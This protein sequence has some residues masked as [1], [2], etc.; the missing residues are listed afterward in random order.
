MSRCSVVRR[1]AAMSFSLAIGSAS[2]KVCI[3]FTEAPSTLM[4]AL[5]VVLDEPDVEIGLQLVDCQIDLLAERNSVELVQ[6]RAMETLANAVIRHDDFGALMFGPFL[7]EKGYGEPIR[8]TGRREHESA[9][10]PPTDPGLR[11]RAR[12][13]AAPCDWPGCAASA[14]Q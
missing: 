14:D 3:G 12:Y 13:M 11:A 9:G 2:R 8:D 4:G 6:D 1:Q 7:R 10:R 5:F